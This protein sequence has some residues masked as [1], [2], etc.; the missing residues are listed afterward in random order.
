MLKLKDKV[1]MDT[2]FILILHM[3][4]FLHLAKVNLIQKVDNRSRKSAKLWKS[5]LTY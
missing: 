5:V 1:G 4:E 2:T 3:I